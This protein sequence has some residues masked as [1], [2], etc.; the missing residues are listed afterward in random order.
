[1]DQIIFAYYADNAQK[2]RRI[3]DKILFKFGGLSNKD[4]DDFY[5]RTR[6]L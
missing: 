3:V 2:L 4:V 5:W 1:M 6:Y